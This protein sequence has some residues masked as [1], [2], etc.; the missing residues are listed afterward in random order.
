MGSVGGRV[1]QG[2][3]LPLPL[4][5][6]LISQPPGATDSGNHFLGPQGKCPS[7]AGQALVPVFALGI[8]EWQDAGQAAGSRAEL[9]GQTVPP[10]RPSS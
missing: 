5:L 6:H 4:P 2:I 9:C 7:P 8:N 10:V 1:P 3:W